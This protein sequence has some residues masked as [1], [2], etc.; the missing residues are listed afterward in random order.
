MIESMSEG[1]IELLDEYST[2][3]DV[4]LLY[5]HMSL[6]VLIAYEEKFFY[7]NFLSITRS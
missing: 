1:L 6:L 7:K 3:W 5:I 4:S 2:Q